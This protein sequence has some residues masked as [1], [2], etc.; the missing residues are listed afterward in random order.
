MTTIDES[1]LDIVSYGEEGSNNFT[2]PASRRRLS[3]VGVENLLR[4]RRFL[5]VDTT[6][7]VEIHYTVTAVAEQ[8]GYTDPYAFVTHLQ[9]E[10]TDGYASPAINDDFVQLAVAG[11]SEAVDSSTDVKFLPPRF[12]ANIRVNVVIT[13]APTISPTAFNP[14]SS[15]DDSSVINDYRYYI[16][17]SVVLFLILSAACV[18]FCCMNRPANN[19]TN[20]AQTDGVTRKT[21]APFDIDEVDFYEVTSAGKKNSQQGS[22]ESSASASKRRPFRFGSG[23][24]STGASA[25]DTPSSGVFGT[26]MFGSGTSV[27]KSES[28]T[29]E[30][31]M[32][33]VPMMDMASIRRAGS[34]TAAGNQTPAS[35][36]EASSGGAVHGEEKDVITPKKQLMM[37]SAAAIAMPA[38]K[39]SQIRKKRSLEKATS[40]MASDDSSGQAKTRSPESAVTNDDL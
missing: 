39:G 28:R 12:G 29:V 21:D 15:N 34:G 20:G 4:S 18:C 27:N 6:I 33:D 40:S 25:A 5:V 37:K 31:D 26:R 38:P 10:I 23:S 2:I 7:S 19:D 17:G 8:N 3:S 9:E 22:V 32:G 14:R 24:S 13:G 16:I 30:D 35:P 11:G 1:A 36:S